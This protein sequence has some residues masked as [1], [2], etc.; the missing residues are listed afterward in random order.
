[1]KKDKKQEYSLT[2]K[3][4]KELREKQNLPKKEEKV[5][6][7]SINNQDNVGNE[8]F[9]NNTINSESI[10]T[11]NNE[12][13]VVVSS[14]KSRKKLFA[15]IAI[16]L[17]VILITLGI[18]LPLFVFNNPYKS[19]SNPVA[20]INLS[21]G[22]RK[23]KVEVEI[24][25]REAPIAATNFLFLAQIGFFDDTIIFDTQN[26][27]VRFGGY[28]SYTSHRKDNKSFY[29]KIKE[30]QISAETGKNKFGYALEPDSS[31]RK[32]DNSFLK[33]NYEYSA[34][35]LS[36]INNTTYDYN[37]MAGHAS[38]N[39]QFCSA[40]STIGAKVLEVNDKE[41]PSTDKA[42]KL[43]ASPFGKVINDSSLNILKEIASYDKITEDSDEYKATKYWVG[44]QKQVKIT[45]VKIYNMQNK[46]KWKNFNFNSF[47]AKGNTYF[48][49]TSMLKVNKWEPLK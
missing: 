33:E 44:P 28:E 25:E 12:V 4:R 18:V 23:M 27:F 1:M 38:S 49:G 24:F 15:I 9:E 40:D 47:F 2:A 5:I 32:G 8:D 19:F 14:T 3:Q 42:R 17:G 26:D 41:N 7:S 43:T 46:S 36:F 10:E 35:Y 30:K 34:G 6:A 29:N 45:N 16:C 48:D 39:F 11:G 37:D 31:A 13:G 22:S 21:D 20:V